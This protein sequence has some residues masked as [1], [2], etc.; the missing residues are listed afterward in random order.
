MR[1]TPLNACAVA[2]M[3]HANSASFLWSPNQRLQLT[4]DARDAL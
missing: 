3:L 2:L 1:R 4:G